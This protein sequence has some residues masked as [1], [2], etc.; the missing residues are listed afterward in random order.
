MGHAMSRIFTILTEIMPGNDPTVLT[1]LSRLG[2]DGEKIEIDG[3]PLNQFAALTFGLFAYGASQQGSLHVL[4]EIKQIFAKTNF[5]Q[6]VLEKF[7]RVR[8]NT[9]DEFRSLFS[10]NSAPAREAFSEEL[11]QSAFL[12]ESLNLF[13]RH[14]FL[15]LSPDQVLTLD[16]QFVAELLTSGVYWSIYDSL[17]SGKRDTFKE[18]WG[19][20]FELYSVNLIA[21]FYPP[22]A[23]MLSVDIQ[24]T[25]GQIDAL[26]DFGSFVLLIEIK[27][28]LLTESAKRNAD[29]ASFLAD[30]RRKFVEN[31]KG[32]PKVIRQLAAACRAILAG[33]IKTASTSESSSK[34]EPPVIYPIFVS[35]EPTVE[36]TFMNAFFN[37]EFQKEGLVAQKVKPLTVMSIDELEQILPH[38]TDND[39]TWEELLQSR[40]NEF[41]VY[42]NSVGQA[43]YDL[44]HV[45]SLPH[46]QNPGLKRKYDEFAEIM[47]AIFQ[48]PQ[49]E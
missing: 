39:F 21:H 44:L 41:G 35:D 27:S 23:N 34:F 18:L 14:P 28:S 5:P 6:P 46:K 12:T 42:P 31:E 2:I 49:Q 29:K 13:R 1:L 24:Y 43:I 40:F 8:A 4:I 19:R 7:L 32:K 47:R 16:R 26:L 17:P 3:I 25:D 48:E 11:K 30:F 22:I 33:K 38:V 36:A 45:K 20:M 15:R 9:L 37:E 10:K